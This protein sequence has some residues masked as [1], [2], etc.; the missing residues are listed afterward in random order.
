MGL[1][2][3]RGNRLA[4]E[5]IWDPC[6]ACLN[7]ERLISWRPPGSWQLADNGEDLGDGACQHVPGRGRLRIRSG[8][9]MEDD[10]CAGEQAYGA[11]FTLASAPW[12]TLTVWVYVSYAANYDPAD[13][14]LG[15]RCEYAIDSDTGGARWMKALTDQLG[16]EFYDDLA[17]ADVAARVAAEKLTLG[18]RSG[19][20]EEPAETWD[21]DGTPW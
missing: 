13:F 4:R 11:T 12:A 9:S 8:L 17:V 7:C 5:V 14:C 3:R 2:T 1:F 10:G 6:P 20:S 21:W 19:V 15:A 16:G 18:P